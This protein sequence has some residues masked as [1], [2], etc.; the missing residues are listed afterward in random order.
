MPG[1]IP[2]GWLSYQDA[3]SV[4]GSFHAA[5]ATPKI[6]ERLPVGGIQFAQSIF[7]EEVPVNLYPLSMAKA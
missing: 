2:A 1:K 6:L 4:E 5:A 7:E 3:G